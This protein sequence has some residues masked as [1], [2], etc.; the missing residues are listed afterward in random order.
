MRWAFMSGAGGVGKTTVINKLEQRIRADEDD[1]FLV[2]SP[3]REIYARIGTLDEKAYAALSAEGKLEFNVKLFDAMFSIYD[4][5]V[6]EADNRPMLF[7]RSPIDYFAYCVATCEVTL[8]YYQRGFERIQNF[9]GDGAL[10]IYFPFPPH[11]ADFHVTSDDGFRHVDF[12]KNLRWDLGIR[13]LGE[14]LVGDDW[15]T[16]LMADA[17]SRV[18]ECYVIMEDH[19]LFDSDDSDA[20]KGVDGF[21]FTYN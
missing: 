19:E 2:K 9:F 21:T 16:L 6:F 14:T 8:A 13:A 3:T 1:L 7:E 15:A 4:E 10:H 17:D 5:K 11:W 18:D 12:A 20:D